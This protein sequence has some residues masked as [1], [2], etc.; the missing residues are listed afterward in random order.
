MKTADAAQLFLWSPI[1]P[2]FNTVPGLILTVR[3][4]DT[5]FK[6]S[7]NYGIHIE[8]RTTRRFNLNLDTMF[9]S[10]FVYNFCDRLAGRIINTS[11]RSGSD[12]NNV[13]SMNICGRR[14]CE[15]EKSE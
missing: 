8:Y 11:Y 7:H 6:I 3:L 5:E 10:F 13:L 4:N 15:K 12:S 9:L 14:T 1:F 2:V